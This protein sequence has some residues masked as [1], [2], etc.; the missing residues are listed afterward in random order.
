MVFSKKY[1]DR[2][3]LKLTWLFLC[4][5]GLQMAIGQTIQLNEE[6]AVANLMDY[7]V[8]KNKAKTEISGYR[9]QIIA[10]QDLRRMERELLIFQNRFPD[11]NARTEYVKPYYKIHVGEFVDEL[12][13][14]NTLV[15]IQQKYSSAFPVHVHN[16]DPKRLL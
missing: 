15:R 11:I 5:F 10:T 9:I 14:K 2:R 7:Y 4:F 12:V 1:I 3:I 13:A 8:L 6:P 16:I